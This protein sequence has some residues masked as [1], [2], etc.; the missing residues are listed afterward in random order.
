MG[1]KIVRDPLVDR[2]IVRARVRPR[3]G[4]GD[5]I[6]PTLCDEITPPGAVLTPPSP[7]TIGAVTVTVRGAAP[8]DAWS[9]RG[10]KVRV[11]AAAHDQVL[12]VTLFWVNTTMK[13][14][15]IGMAFIC[16][17]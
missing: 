12:M 11:A 4:N 5:Q 17:S 16:S 8:F 6:N 1:G 3:S 7:V 13:R 9:G 10:W 15:S 14:P 2:D